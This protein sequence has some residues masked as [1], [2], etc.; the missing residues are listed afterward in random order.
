MARDASW[1]VLRLNLHSEGHPSILRGTVGEIVAAKSLEIKD[2]FFSESPEAL[3][4]TRHV[5]VECR[6]EWL[7][8][9]PGTVSRALAR[10][11]ATFMSFYNLEPR[12]Q[13]LYDQI[14]SREP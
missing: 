12:Y 5:L 2:V 6:I 9:W 13:G 11:G 3:E 7:E 14:T 4:P 1:V 8:P 10:S